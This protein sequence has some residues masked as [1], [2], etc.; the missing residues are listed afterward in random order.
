MVLWI[1]FRLDLEIVDDVCVEPRKGVNQRD[2]NLDRRI[3]VH[4]HKIAY[5]HADMMPPPNA[6]GM[7]FMVKRKEG[8][9]AAAKV[10]TV[11]EALQRRAAG[12][13]APAH[14]TAT[15]PLDPAQVK[16]SNVDAFN[17]YKQDES[18][19]SK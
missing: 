8:L 1:R 11:R 15:P 5:Y 18:M 16:S 14:Y 10:E 3:D 17:P 7:A 19:H 6:S 4:K 13:P 9:E 2:L 12:K